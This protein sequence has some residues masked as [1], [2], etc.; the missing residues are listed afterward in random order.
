MDHYI[1]LIS[2]VA[3]G[4]PL[5]IA[6]HGEDQGRW[7]HIWVRVYRSYML[8]GGGWSGDVIQRRPSSILSLIASAVSVAKEASLVYLNRKGEEGSGTCVCYKL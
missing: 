2:G 5:V 3:E 4:G 6:L 8:L 7:K 1:L